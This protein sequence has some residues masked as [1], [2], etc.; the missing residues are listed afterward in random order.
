MN[1]IKEQGWRI[2]AYNPYIFINNNKDLI[3]LLHVNDILVF[4]RQLETILEFKKEL[5]TEFSI[6]DEGECS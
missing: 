1:S 2:S 4:G 6:T 3:L 5:A